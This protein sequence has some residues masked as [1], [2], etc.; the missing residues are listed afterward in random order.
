[1]TVSDEI[2]DVRVN[3]QQCSLIFEMIKKPTIIL[4]LLS[5]QNQSSKASISCKNRLKKSKN[6]RILGTSYLGASSGILVL[7]EVFSPINIHL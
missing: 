5:L 4:L 7:M 1:M 2:C 3:Q 6:V